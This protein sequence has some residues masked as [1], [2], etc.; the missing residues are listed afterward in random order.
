MEVAFPIWGLGIE[1]RV[2][3]VS[4][5][6]KS[7]MPNPRYIRGHMRD[8]KS[9]VRL[10]PAICHVEKAHRRTPRARIYFGFFFTMSFPTTGIVTSV[11]TP[12]GESTRPASVAV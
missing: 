3:V 9:D 6:N 2:R 7:P 1:E 5:M 11:A 4:G 12:P 8:E 10:N